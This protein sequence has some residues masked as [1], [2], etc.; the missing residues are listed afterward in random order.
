MEKVWPFDIMPRV[1]GHQ[2]WEPVAPGLKTL[3]DAIDIRRRILVAFEKA[4]ALDDAEE[5]ERLLT[6]VVIGGGATGVEMAGAIAEL[7][8][9]A[10][11][12]DFRRI[13]SSKARIILVEAGPR[14]LPAY[15]ERLSASAL[16]SLEKLGVDPA[17]A[18]GAF[19]TT[20]TDVV[21]FFAF[22]GLA[23]RVLL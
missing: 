5:R 4:E 20:V 21:G 22:L 17:L 8:K 18:S 14:L 10:L 11:K 15:P 6:F 9:T 13:D 3:E 12:R 19:V 7:A 1:I 23:A 2:E 16:R